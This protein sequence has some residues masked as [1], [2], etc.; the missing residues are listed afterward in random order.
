M[1]TNLKKRII[2]SVILIP[3]AVYIT[4][5]G[6]IAF[7]STIAIV[8][9]IMLF[10]WFRIIAPAKKKA[11]WGILGIAYIAIP[12]GALAWLRE[13]QDSGLYIIMWIIATVWASDIGAYITGKI[14]GGPKLAPK[15]S[16]GK[17][18]SGAIGG[19]IFG[20]VASV[21]L[22]YNFVG[23]SIT[24]SVLLGIFLVISAQLGDLFESWVKRKFGVKDSGSLIPGHGGLLDR[25]DSL[26][27]AATAAAIYLSF[28]IIEK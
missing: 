23:F 12:C 5:T 26:L 20:T 17:T 7:A 2:S 16:P 6:G 19:L 18:W 11:L 10:E 4:Y 24:R 15:I 8:G 27:F 28:F 14:I 25:L 21:Y 22:T 1:E 9:V 13:I 3:I